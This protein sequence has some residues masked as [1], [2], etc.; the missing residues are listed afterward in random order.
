MTK[1]MTL[2]VVSKVMELVAN[3][4]KVFT[5]ITFIFYWKP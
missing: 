1:L 4:P 2:H 5:Q 3:N